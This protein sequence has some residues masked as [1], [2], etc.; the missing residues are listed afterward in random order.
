MKKLLAFILVAG[1]VGFISC[2]PSQKDKDAAAKKTKD[3]L[4]AVAKEK[5][6]QDSLAEIQKQD[7]IKKKHVEDSI[8]DAKKKQQGG[9][10]IPPKTQQQIQKQNVSKGR[11]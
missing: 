2:G 3:S 4:D 6:T 9:T 10:Y 7:S 8:A 11:G 1:M 5:R